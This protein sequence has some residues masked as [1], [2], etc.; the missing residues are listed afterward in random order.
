[1]DITLNYWEHKGLYI[2]H[3]TQ[4]YRFTFNSKRSAQ[5]F[6]NKCKKEFKHHLINVNTFYIEVYSL[7]RQYHFFLDHFDQR[8][9]TEIFNGILHRMQQCVE[10]KGQNANTL[11]YANIHNAYH[12]LITVNKLLYAHLK[13]QSHTQNVYIIQNNINTIKL[14]YAQFEQITFIENNYELPKLKIA[15]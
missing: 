5:A 15:I 13:K 4:E 6:V 7:Y 3:F 10:P 2:V 8:H 12:E 11:I 9:Y 1:M 14:N